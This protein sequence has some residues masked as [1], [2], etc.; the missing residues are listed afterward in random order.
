MTDHLKFKSSGSA[1]VLAGGNV[2]GC[3]YVLAT[4]PQGFSTFI[5]AVAQALPG[6]LCN[7][8]CKVSKLPAAKGFIYQ[9]QESPRPHDTTCIVISAA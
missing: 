8:C 3:G 5:K 2:F 7:H 1:T 4:R 6:G 9:L